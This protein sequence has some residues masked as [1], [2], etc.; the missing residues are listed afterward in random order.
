M[1]SFITTY[2]EEQ[3]EKTLWEFWLHKVFD[4]TSYA[5]FRDRM[6]QKTETA[7]PTQIDLN[8]TV[9]T[10]FQMLAGFSLRGGAQED[11]TIQTAG[12]NSG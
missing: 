11:G 8:E 1:D 9:Q 6:K 7:A 3:E 5:D 12:Y 4:K 10:S 2:N